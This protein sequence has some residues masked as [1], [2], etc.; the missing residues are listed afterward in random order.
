MKKSRKLSKKGAGDRHI[1]D[2]KPKHLLSGKR[3]AG[4][5]SRR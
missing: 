1:F 2:L 3:K 5:T 4:K